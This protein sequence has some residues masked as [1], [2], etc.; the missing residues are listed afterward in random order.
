[1]DMLNTNGPAARNDGVAHLRDS[2]APNAARRSGN[3]YDFM[4]CIRLWN[5]S[6]AVTNRRPIPRF[7]SGF[8]SHPSTSDA[9]FIIRRSPDHGGTGKLRCDAAVAE[10]HRETS[11]RYRHAAEAYQRPLAQ[12]MANTPSVSIIRSIEQNM[13]ER[14]RSPSPGCVVLA[15]VI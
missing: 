8:Q 9:A 10:S 4:T 13:Q 12:F 1:M 15:L 5:L 6:N 3:P 11:R 7:S 14:N 2:V